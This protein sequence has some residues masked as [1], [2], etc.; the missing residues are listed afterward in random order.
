[1]HLSALR[2]AMVE[3][4]GAVASHHGRDT[5]DADPHEP[6]H[7]R[8]AQALAAGETAT[9]AYKLAGYKPDRRNASRLTTNDDIKARV[10]ELQALAADG[11]VL[12]REWVLDGLQGEGRSLHAT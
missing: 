12:T 9:A 10:A 2:A 3:M 11:A 4:L 5:D 6:R 8:F 7:E 1:M